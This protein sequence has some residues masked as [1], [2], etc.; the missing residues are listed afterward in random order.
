MKKQLGAVKQ[1]GCAIQFIK[2]PSLDVQLEAVKQ[3][4]C[5]IQFIKNPSLE[6]INENDSVS[7][8]TNNIELILSK[9]Y[10]PESFEYLMK[11]NFKFSNKFKSSSIYKEYLIDYEV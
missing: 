3:Y 10:S 1:D 9:I 11:R 5:A 8:R 2:N 4:G 7:K 6:M